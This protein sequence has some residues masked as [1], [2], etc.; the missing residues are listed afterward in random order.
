[1]TPEN[2]IEINFQRGNF[3]IA[4]QNRFWIN[5]GFRKRFFLEK[6]SYQR[7]PFSR[8]SRKFRDSRD[9]RET[10]TVE[11]EGESENVSCQMTGQETSAV[12]PSRPCPYPRGSGMVP[13]CL[14]ENTG[15][16]KHDLLLMKTDCWLGD[17]FIYTSS[18]DPEVLQSG[19]GVIFFW[20]VW[21]IFGKV[22]ANFSANFDGD[23]FVREIFGLVSLGLQALHKNSRPK[24]TPEIVGIPLQSHTFKPNFFLTL[25]FCLRGRPTSAGNAAPALYRNLLP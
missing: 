4:P 17:R 3:K 13:S 10:Q 6:G 22:P 23:F 1:M 18:V 9:F 16:A 25:I 20:G 11:N 14:L 8:D 2:L 21:R 5:F 7:S 12:A 15:R 19:F 24:S